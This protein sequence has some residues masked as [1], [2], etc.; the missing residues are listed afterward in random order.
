[1]PPVI[2][3]PSRRPVRFHGTNFRAWLPPQQ[4]NWQRGS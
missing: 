2:R 3:Q 1:M 4:L